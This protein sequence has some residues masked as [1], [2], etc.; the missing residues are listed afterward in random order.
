MQKNYGALGTSIL[1]LMF[2]L[3]KGPDLL[4]VTLSHLQALHR[5]LKSPRLSQMVLDANV[6]ES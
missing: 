1:C 6:Y 2:L 4:H 3:Q 5:C